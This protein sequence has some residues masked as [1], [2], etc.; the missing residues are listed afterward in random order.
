MQAPTFSLIEYGTGRRVSLDNFQGQNVML[1]F[2]VSWCPDCHR[3]LPKKQ[4][5]YDSTT[6]E[7][8][9]LLTINVTGREGEEGDGIEFIENH[10]FTFPVLYDE[11]TKIY[12]AY[13]CTSVP[14]TVFLNR[15]H[16]ITDT[17]DDQDSFI[18][19][20]EALGKLV[21]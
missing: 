12:D 19:I 3:D 21:D 9:V 1:T 20:V 2:W 18:D 7:D 5:L 11:E 17:F 10:D 14:T 4:Q 16:E 13:K 6:D 8:I 15:K